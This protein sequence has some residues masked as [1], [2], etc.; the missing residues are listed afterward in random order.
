MVGTR[1]RFPAE[2]APC[3]KMVGGEYYR[4]DD[5]EGL[6]IYDQYYEC[7]CRRTRHDYHDGSVTMTEKKH[8]KAATQ[9]HSP[10]HPV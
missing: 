9:A 4:E 6:V 1:T 2:L 5:G 7:G 3:G 8:G 10:E